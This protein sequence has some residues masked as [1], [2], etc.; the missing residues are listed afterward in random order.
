[1]PRFFRSALRVAGF[2]F[3]AVWW[4][5]NSE[6][7]SEIAA[8]PSRFRNR[9]VARLIL[10]AVVAFVVLLWTVFAPAA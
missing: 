6:G 8:A 2:A 3:G 4:T 9:I 7:S 1:M 10:L 5:R